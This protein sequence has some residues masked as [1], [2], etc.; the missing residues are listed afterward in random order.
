MYIREVN[1]LKDKVKGLVIG[2]LLGSA[3][4]GTAAFAATGTQIEVMFRPLTFLFDGVEK[5]PSE[6]AAFIY[7]GSTYVPLRFVSETLGKEVGW[8]GDTGT[9]FIDEPGSKA[10]VAAYKDGE[11]MISI[12]QAHVNK[13]LAIAQ[14]YNPSTTQ[15]LNDPGLISQMVNDLATFQL[16]SGRADTALLDAARA[17][18]P[19]RLAELKI[20][21][22]MYFKGQMEWDSRLKELKLTEADLLDYIRLQNIRAEYM[23]SQVSD[24]Q[25]KSAY[26]QAAKNHDFDTATVRHVLIGFEDQDGKPRTKEAALERAK[27]ALTKLKTAADFKEVALAYSDDPG[28]KENGGLYENAGVGNWVEGFKNAVLEQ[29]IGQIGEPVETEYGYHVILVESRVSPGFDEVREVLNSRLIDNIYKNWIEVELP[30]L[31]QP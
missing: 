30:K 6:G 9:I 10:V 13:Q 31:K 1:D 11:R 25:L 19:E 20:N 21:F 29:K 18:A 5:K 23:K 8:D 24:E 14:L 12:N 4:T 7:D 27:E 2:A 17:A 3:I 28:S 15:Y 16:A 22:E 26:D